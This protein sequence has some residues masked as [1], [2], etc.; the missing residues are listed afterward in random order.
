[1]AI[2]SASP[3]ARSSHQR[4]LEDGAEPQAWA[5]RQAPDPAR[6]QA[7]GAQQPAA[8]DAAPDATS[9][10]AGDNPGDD[11]QTSLLDRLPPPLTLEP[12]AHTAFAGRAFWHSRRAP[13]ALDNLPEPL[14]LEP[15]P[16]P[17]AAA[18]APA[19][20]ALAAAAPTPPP[21]PPS[22]DRGYVGERA[23]EPQ[24][25][26]SRELTLR[27]IRADY[28]AQRGQAQAR[29]PAFGETAPGW[30][31]ATLVTD[32]SGQVRSASGA[33]VVFVAD[34]HG[35]PA[36]IGYDESGPVYGPAPGRTLE[37]NEEAFA[38]HYRSAGG[39]PLQTLAGLYGSDAATL[40]AQHPELWSLATQDHALNAGPPP[41]G[42]AMGDP[43]QLGTLDL[44]MADSQIAAL[45]NTYGGA[46][47][48]ATGGI[49]R[50]QVRIYGQARYE[51]LTRL[52]Q[53]MQV[54]RDDYSRAMAQAAS[55]GGVGWVERQRT[56][57]VSDESGVT[58]TELAFTSD[59][60][61]VRTPLIDRVFDPDVFTRW[62][63]AQ[64]GIANRAFADFYGQSHTQYS[65][66][67]SGATH[68]ST[69]TFDNANWTM[70]GTGGGMSHREL[71][72][73][74][75]NHTP[76]L[77]NNGA[78]GFDLEAGW[79][80]HHSNIHQKRDWFET[81]VQVAI[82]GV[83]SWVSAGTLGA[84]AAGAVG[85][86]F[87]GAVASAAV[88]GA[89]ASAASGMINGN[90]TF[91]GV[92]Q[93]ALSGALTAGLMGSLGGAV[94]NVAGTAGT[95]ALRAT[96]QG[97]IQ[98][99][100][101]G[102]FRDGALAGLASGLADAAGAN[103][104]KGID[105]ALANG[106]MTAAEAVAARMSARVLSS[107]IRTLGNPDDPQ[108]AFASAFV[109]SVVNDGLDASQQPVGTT[110]GATPPAFDDEGFLMPG[111]VDA[112]AS[113]QEQAAQLSAH[114]QRQGLSAEE[115]AALSQQ[116][117]LAPWAQTRT[118]MLAALNDPRTAQGRLV[119]DND[120][121]HALAEVNEEMGI[122]ADGEAVMRPVG[123][124]DDAAS[125]VSRLVSRAG[126]QLQT[127]V[128]KV[129][130]AI[131]IGRLEEAQ[132]S[133]ASYLDAAAARGGL[134]EVEIMALG[135]VYAANAT[136]FPTTA[137]D[138]IPG[139]GKALSKV[140]DVIRSGGRADEVAA[141][142]RLESRAMAESER[143]TQLRIAE[144]SNR[145]AREGREVIPQTRGTSGDWNATL[146]G[147]LKTNAVYVLD[148]GH[149]YFTDGLGRVTRAEGV[150][151][152]QRVDRNAY[153][154][155]LAGKAG[156]DGYDG[157]H[158]LA[159]VFGGAGEKVNLV[160]QLSEVN[161]GIFREMERRWALAIKD[162]KYV[163]VEVSPI[164]V[165]DSRVP[166]S[167]LVNFRVDGKAESR[168]FP[169]TPTP[170]G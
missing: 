63:T 71:V 108:Y 6:A 75:P 166:G 95:V 130:D 12:E 65:T 147:P 152:L 149:S 107:A 104:S 150:L 94:Q 18:A 92:L 134:S 91:K 125:Y 129:L 53:A 148:N 118:Q 168:L 153:Q 126:G 162:G 37:F 60:S 15:S 119:T 54:V 131:A 25:L 23:V 26:Q 110:P 27:A 78:V 151:D 76:R 74:D 155:A 143:L 160:A 14:L 4:L 21:P 36:V 30:I 79:A 72:S 29:P 97:G 46:V 64:D 164:Y 1:M 66:D 102:K 117:I 84:A 73:L 120:H 45:I 100:L 83:V 22:A 61:G 96:V 114:L 2:H 140:G 62:Y 136:L 31:D 41:P 8:P 68:A 49:A 69:I 16:P 123:L 116:T 57:T 10:G 105:D 163:Q 56:V 142:T 167:I 138:I 146:N 13:S 87:A 39:E 88:V 3:Y 81:L 115:S 139:A 58:R 133:I 103:I 157:G 156:G 67:E 80:T 121:D 137:L 33:Q 141:A 70:Q 28:E 17:M 145:A 34:P 99:L 43:S 40:L 35:S 7:G 59:E 85:G 154:Q 169:N 89:A 135:V 124:L 144:V 106:S 86:G 158:L 47:A 52:G 112:N 98:A 24:W 77:N 32:E 128:G 111:I 51:Q 101:G 109:S 55:S 50:E 161:R 19:A 42:R 170:G 122:S 11:Q 90:L 44:Y 132:Q 82:V 165:G 48:P 113:P 38:A 127:T 159:T 5:R 9:G 93:G 20:A